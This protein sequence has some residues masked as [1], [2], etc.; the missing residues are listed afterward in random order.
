MLSFSRIQNIFSQLLLALV[1]LGNVFLFHN[2]KI[3]LIF[4]LFYLWLNSKKIADMYASNIHQGLKNVMGLLT[5]LAY[6]SLVY[7]MA[8][9]LWQINI[10]IWLFVFLSI[11]LAVEILSY[12]QNS[13][14]YFLTNTNFGFLKISHIRKTILPLAV[15][16]LDIIL[17]SALFKKASLGIIRSPWEL[18]GFRFW[19]VFA[20]SNFSLAASIIDQKSYKNIILICW[21]FFLI[22]SIGI[23]LYPLGYGYDS[24]IH[25][26][27]L[28]NINQ[29]G[30]IEP[31]LFL[32]IGQYALTFFLSNILQIS[33]ATANKLLMPALFSIFWPT[34]L[35]Y[36]LRYGFNWSYKASY[37]AVLWSL[38]IGFNFAIM[39]TP[40]SL[41]FLLLAIFVF[42]L[43]EINKKTISLYFTL[44]LSLMALTIHPLVGI[45][46]LFFTTILAIWKLKK[47]KKTNLILKVI[48]YGSSIMI[49]PVLFA[50]Y[51]KINQFSW[52]EIIKI[53][54]WPIINL[55]RIFWFKSYSFPLDM[56]HNIGANQFWIYSLIVLLGVYAIFRE[57]KY[58]FFKRL[59]I[60][61]GLI[62]ANYLLASIFLSF[63]LQ[64]S[65]QKHDYINRIVFMLA[66]MLLPIFL[67]A[68]YFWWSSVLKKNK[69]SQ[70][71]FIAVLTTMVISVSTYFSYPVYDQHANSK[72][73][74]IT[75]TDLKTVQA[76][77]NDAQGQ[78]YI[79]LA[80]QMLGAAAIYQ[81]GFRNYYNENFYYSM[82]L[83]SDNIYQNF[84]N[85]IENEASVEEVVMAMDKAG[86]DKVYFVVNNY[87]HSAKQAIKQA[88]ETADKK[89]S[90]DNGINTVF[91]YNR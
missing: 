7:T 3:G 68:V 59:L 53:N 60:F 66:I 19:L 2:T 4:G 20:L 40:Q 75:S 69:L 56:I 13:R 83:G 81:Y 91:I 89:L 76:I 78:N 47:H 50:I 14:H 49:L 28:E 65:Y 72:S 87:W 71:T 27:V 32:Y 46:M 37:L 51:Q 29:T 43:P 33:I 73:F 6:I 36:G 54:W 12:Y 44:L 34:S 35:Y 84:L 23:I 5:I 8:Y 15:I 61:S 42:I 48:A 30:T 9:H 82:P 74:N 18:V 39:T 70:K 58:I 11:P 17:V 79:V 57:N 90:I 22:S 45:P 62:L 21:H 63:N 64:I 88:E 31:R 25:L 1:I 26:A 67:T 80:N 16:V 38:F 41:T 77:E 24:F 52:Q 55:P 86:V 85:M 10:Y